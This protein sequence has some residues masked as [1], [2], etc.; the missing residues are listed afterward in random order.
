MNQHDDSLGVLAEE[1]IAQLQKRSWIRRH[2]IS[3][4]SIIIIVAFSAVI[5][6]TGALSGD[7]WAYGYLGVFLVSILGS[8]VI[9]VPIPSMPVV[10]LMGMILN[11]WLVALMVGL[12]EPIGEIPTYL[13]GRG[14][15]TSM[16]KWEKKRFFRWPTKFIRNRPSLFLFFFALLPNPA[17]DLAGATTGAMHYPFWK[18]LIALFLGKTGKGLI[19]AF[20]GYWTL[21]LL[22][23]LFIG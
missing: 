15:R 10:F 9:L 4:V 7:L 2:W 12:G 22:L 18:F 17:F 19:I 14:G 8:V 21:H 23:K 5:Y 13:A 20:A 3:L 11:P 16:E 1:D 6:F